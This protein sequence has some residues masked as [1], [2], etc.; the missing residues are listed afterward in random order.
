MCAIIHEGRQTLT[1]AHTSPLQEF[2][3]SSQFSN[4]ERETRPCSISRQQEELAIQGNR[5]SKVV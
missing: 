4:F 1:P 5:I 3:F 2:Q